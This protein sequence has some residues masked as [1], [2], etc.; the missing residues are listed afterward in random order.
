MHESDDGTCTFIEPQGS[1][2]GPTLFLIYINNLNNITLLKMEFFMFADDTLLL[3]HDTKWNRVL[4][5][6]ESGFSKVR[7]ARK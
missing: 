6:T 1:I 2:I 5:M 3:F 4:Q 7:V